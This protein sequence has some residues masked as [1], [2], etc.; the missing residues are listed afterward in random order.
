MNHTDT[1]GG[2]A[3]YDGLD[4]GALE[5]A[6]AVREVTALQCLLDDGTLAPEATAAARGDMGTIAA[7]LATRKALS[8]T[9]TDLIHTLQETATDTLDNA[10]ATALETGIAETRAEIAGADAK[11]S[12]LVTVSTGALAGLVAFAHARVPAAAAAVLWA[13]ALATAAALAV[14]LWGVLRPRLGS[15]ARTGTFATT[16]QLLG[17]ETRA[18]LYR[19]RRDRLDLFDRTAVAKNLRVL[20]AVCLLAAALVL[21]IAGAVL[22]ALGGAA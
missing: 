1:I 22:A 2:Y 6:S 8:D 19:W 9:G 16:V 13:A 20:L 10:M 4:D 5:A 17:S 12:T 15:A 7:L 14:L 11:T 18:D 21:L 3:G